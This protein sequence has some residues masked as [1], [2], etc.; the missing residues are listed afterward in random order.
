MMIRLFL[1][2][3]LLVGCSTPRLTTGPQPRALHYY[4]LLPPVSYG[5]SLGIEQLLDGQFQENHF[6]LHTLLEIDADQILVLGFTA[7]QTRAFVIRYDGRALEFENFTD[8]KMP[9]PPEMI[10]SDI[11]QVFWPVLPNRDGWRIVDETTGKMRLVFFEDQLV[12]RIQY[13]GMSPTT[14]DIELSNMKY[15][16]QLHIRPVHVQN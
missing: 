16:Y 5:R 8:R 11:Q 12:T 1:L 10:L 2:L 4:P 9:F 3:P 13:N 15:G 6:R 14:G 7:F